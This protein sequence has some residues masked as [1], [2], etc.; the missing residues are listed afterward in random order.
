MNTV[1]RI[2]E[3]AKQ[4]FEN[5]KESH[6]AGEIFSSM[7]E[8]RSPRI[9]EIAVGMSGNYEANYKRI[10]RFLKQTNPKEQL[11]MLF[12]EE[13]E[14]VICD[15]TE[16]TR[17]HA[18]KTNYVGTL[19]DGKTK[20]FWMM[21][22]ATPLRGRAIPFNF[23]TYS[24]RTFE[25]QVS[26]RNLEHH[27][28]IQEVLALV[29][30]RPVIF[31]REFSYL[32]LLSSMLEAELDFIVR[33]DMRSNPPHFYY[34][35]DLKVRLY[36]RIAPIG[37]P[38]IYRQVYYMGQVKMNVI[39]IWNYGFKD[40]IWIMTTLEPEEALRLY[41]K[42]MKI[43]ISFRDLKSLLQMDK[44]MNKSQVYL[45]KMLALLMIAYA[46]FLLLGEAI[47][48]VQYAQ[49]NPDQIDLLAIPPTEK[50]SKWHSFSG[51]FLLLK[52]RCT[53]GYQQLRKIVSIVLLLFSEIVFG[54]SVRSFVRT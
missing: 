10:Q 51:P 47:R 45:E 37:K 9:S 34:D 24:S 27:K 30:D 18:E 32:E 52:R 54:K 48:D 13:A 35:R 11:Q 14:Y 19:R 2:T 16:I 49:V 50:R 31:D 4:L 20:G 43:E 40:P 26:S 44:I 7:L 41:F 39:G 3:F 25:E 28:A 17:P 5:E 36:L 12:N 42:R 21:T 29:G 46:I 8:V 33:L 1:L 6:Q 53:L 15:P 23:L 38:Q 22:F